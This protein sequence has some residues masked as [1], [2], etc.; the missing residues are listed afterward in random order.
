MVVLQP[1]FIIFCTGEYI[2]V[3]TNYTV[4][5]TSHGVCV[6]YLALLSTPRPITAMLDGDEF[7]SNMACL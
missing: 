6:H 5:P 2:A 1:L 3:T 4:V 7:Q